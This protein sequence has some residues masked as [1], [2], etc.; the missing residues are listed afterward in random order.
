[1]RR[2]SSSRRKRRRW[3]RR[4]RRR[5]REEDEDEDGRKGTRMWSL[6]LL[7][8]VCRF[9]FVDKCML[10]VSPLSSNSS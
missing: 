1:M 7:S 10:F 8:C 2:T 4:R 5:R 9:F 6:F 3:R